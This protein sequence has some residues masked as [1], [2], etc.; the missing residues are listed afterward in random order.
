MC[1][2]G[3]RRGDDF[4]GDR[5]C[6]G[7]R[8]GTHGV[9]GILDTTPPPRIPRPVATAGFNSSGMAVGTYCVQRPF[10]EQLEAPGALG[11]RK[12]PS[13]AGREELSISLGI[14]P[15]FSTCMLS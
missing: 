4:R 6:T 3:M 14:Q 8:K 13:V 7:L 1:L 9:K 11:Q 5:I 2:I 15:R 12:K 10:D